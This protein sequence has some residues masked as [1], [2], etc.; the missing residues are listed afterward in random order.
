MVQQKHGFSNRARFGSRKAHDANSPAAGRSGDGDDGVI[1]IQVA[2]G[3]L[4]VNE[5]LKY[6]IEAHRW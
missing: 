5:L 3:Y 6:A 4:L 1:Q 2:S